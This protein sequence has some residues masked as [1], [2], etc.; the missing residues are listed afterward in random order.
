MPEFMSAI[1][2]RYCIDCPNSTTSKLLHLRRNKYDYYFG[3]R[4]FFFIMD[5]SKAESVS[6]LE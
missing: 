1:G 6:V 3:H 4:L 2:T 5:F